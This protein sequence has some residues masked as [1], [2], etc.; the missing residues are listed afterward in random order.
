MGAE[1]DLDLIV[2]IEQEQNWRTGHTGP[3]LCFFGG[4]CRSC[5][6]HKCEFQRLLWLKYVNYISYKLPLLF[7]TALFLLQFHIYFQ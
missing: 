7:F 3:L 6:S 4:V 5:F 2:L 1:T